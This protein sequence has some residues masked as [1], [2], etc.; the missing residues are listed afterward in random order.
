MEEYRQ[1]TLDEWTQWKEDIRRKLNETAGN[2]VYIGY[3]LKQIRDSGMFGGAADIFEFA[4][5]EYG[6]GKSTVSRFIAIN[7]RYSEGGNSLELKEEYRGFSSSKLSEMLTLPDSEIE[8]ITEK[9][10]IREIRDLKAFNNE[11][12]KI[13]EGK[14]TGTE[15]AAGTS[16]TTE[17]AAHTQLQK[18]LIDFFKDKKDTLNGIMELLNADPPAYKEAAE[19]MAPAQ[20]SHKK[21]MVFLFMYDWDTGVKYKLMTSPEPAAASWPELLDLVYG[22][23][24]GSSRA[25]AWSDFYKDQAGQQASEKAEAENTA[26]SESNQGLEAVATSQQK[27]K[28]TKEKDVVISQQDEKKDQEAAVVENEESGEKKTQGEDRED[29]EQDRE[30]AVDSESGHDED[31]TSGGAGEDSIGGSAD[32]EGETGVAPVQPDVRLGDQK[33]F[34]AAIGVEQYINNQKKAIMEALPTMQAKCRAGDWDG[35]IEKA[36]DIITIAEAVKEIKEIYRN[37]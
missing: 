25:D 37:E 20:T 22:I 24:G 1:I 26:P 34:A 3:R 36:K 9:T 33:D 14:N 13:P 28:K 11:A 10:T 18:C 29:G 7:E 16:V 19:L 23:F 6:L 12:E 30:P 32:S 17:T 21:G 15:T 5:K 8:L 27:E 35:L 2:F 31:G 4:E